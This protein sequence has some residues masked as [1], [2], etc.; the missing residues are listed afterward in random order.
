MKKVWII[1]AIVAVV[2]LLARA[3]YVLYDNSDGR[4]K[5]E[6][7]S[8]KDRTAR[9]IELKGKSSVEV[10]VP[11]K[12]EIKGEEYTVTEIGQYAFR[13][14]RKLEKVTLPATI[15]DIWA[16]AFLNCFNL[17]EIVIPEGVRRIGNNEYVYFYGQTQEIDGAWVV[18]DEF[19]EDIPEMRHDAKHYMD[20]HAK[21]KIAKPTEEFYAD[22]AF[23]G[24]TS[25]RS[26]SLPA[27]L[28]RIGHYTF[29]DCINLEKIEI[30]DGVKEIGM[31]AFKCCKALSDVKL[32]DSLRVIDTETFA[33]CPSLKTLK[34]PSSLLMI[35][36]MAFH[37]CENLADI[38]LP[39]SIL[40]IGTLAFGKCKSL[41]AIKLPESV[42]DINSEAFSES[43]ITE[44]TIPASVERIGD[45]P[46]ADCQGLV[47]VNVAPANKHFRVADGILFDNDNKRLIY[48]PL[49]AE[50]K[51]YAV[52]E[53]TLMVGAYAFSGN[54]SI[55]SVVLPAS[56]TEIGDCA[57]IGCEKMRKLTIKSETLPTIDDSLFGTE[58]VPSFSDHMETNYLIN[59]GF[60]VILPKGKTKDDFKEEYGWL[61]YIDRDETEVVVEDEVLPDD[62][63]VVEKTE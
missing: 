31:A 56:L 25:L 61:P 45:N 15:T 3:A 59:P 11:E 13:D 4:L 16:G 29:R 54:K 41:K 40:E 43:G 19:K 2:A 9:V 1:I 17:R 23:E 48:Y 8:E 39:D 35:E 27:S 60:E 53:G 52:P 28:Q 24:C 14:S 21:E 62:E 18:P 50:R 55:V 33:Q 44:F 12:T 42:K 51:D 36:S 30:P 10:V 49:K 5:F 46:F 6:V 20:D 34:L 22:G 37:E 63:A 57:F 32:P 38:Q 26:I 58:D 7:V 47:G